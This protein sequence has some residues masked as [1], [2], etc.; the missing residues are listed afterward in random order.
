MQ[1]VSW[2]CN[3][4]GIHDPAAI[5]MTAGEQFRLAPTPLDHAATYQRAADQLAPAPPSSPSLQIF[6]DTK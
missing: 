6:R 4:I 1:F 2:W 5:R 3:L